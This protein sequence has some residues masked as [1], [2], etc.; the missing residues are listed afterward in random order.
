MTKY[1]IEMVSGLLTAL[2]N[3]TKKKKKT[4]RKCSFLKKNVELLEKASASF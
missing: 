3:G 1:L 4:V 2:L